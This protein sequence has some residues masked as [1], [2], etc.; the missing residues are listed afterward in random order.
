MRRVVFLF[1]QVLFLV[2]V[3]VLHASASGI[4]KIAVTASSLVISVRNE[5]VPLRIVELSPI[6]SVD[7]L[8]NAPTVA[9]VSRSGKRTLIVPRFDGARDRV[10]SGFLAV[11]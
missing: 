8:T 11:T 10:Y 5:N 3:L 2:T 4:T 9:V 6:Q 1:L 7:A